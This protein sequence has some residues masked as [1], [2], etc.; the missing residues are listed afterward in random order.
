MHQSWQRGTI[1]TAFL[2]TTA[3]AVLPGALP[4]QQPPP[5]NGQDGIHEIIV[6]GSRIARPDLTA[7]RDRKSVV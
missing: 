4:A 2:V 5:D 6:T 3:L 7:I 1:R